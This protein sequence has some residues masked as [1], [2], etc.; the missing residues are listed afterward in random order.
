M[1]KRCI[2][3]I[4]MPLALATVMLGG[5]A[6][7]QGN[8]NTWIPVGTGDYTNPANWDA[9][10][11]PVLSPFEERAVISN[12]GTA[13]LEVNTAPVVGGVE[14]TSGTL[15]I[16]RGGTLETGIGSSATGAVTIAAGGNLTMGGLTG[17]N[18]STFT[19]AAGA[20]LQGTTNIIGPNANLS[21]A[22]ITL[23]GTLNSTVTAAGSSTLEATGNATL[24][25]PLQ[26]NFSGITPVPGNTWNIIDA[27]TITGAFSQVTSNASLGPGLFFVQKTMAGGMHGTLAQV[28]IDANLILSVNRRT[29]QTSIKNLTSSVSKSIDAYYIT[30]PSNALLPGQWSSFNDNGFTSFR[31]SNPSARHLG[32]LSISG[33]RAIGPN[34]TTALGNIFT[35]TAPPLTPTPG[36]DLTFEFHEAGGATRTGIVDYVGPHNNLVLVVNPD[37]QTFIQNQ[38][39]LNLNVDGYLISSASG[40]LNTSSWVSFADSNAAWRESNPSTKHL[41]ELNIGGSRNFAAGSA[42]VSLGSAFTPGSAKDLVFEF[43]AVGLGTLTGSVEYE[44]GVINFGT[45]PGDFNNDGHVDAA[46]YVVWRKNSGTMNPLPNDDNI[47][48]TIGTA[49]Y[50]LWRANFGTAVGSGSALN[51]AAVPEPGPVVLCLVFATAVMLT[52][53]GQLASRHSCDSAKAKIATRRVYFYR[54]A[55]RIA[56]SPVGGGA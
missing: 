39:T 47:G 41:G 12:G 4:I 40:A 9:G 48:G 25:G 20:T 17:S 32:E 1:I 16:R 56:G 55:E 51:P 52:S 46:D 42:A 22:S 26:L 2:T 3:L 37:G 54:S 24:S 18:P 28:A 29:G 13:F 38:S 30:S 33:S 49:H 19:I 50:N 43:H 34:S 11:V 45:T 44:D 6:I 36:G 27:A 21:A 8:P 7:G 31:E 14:V 35:A 10:G 15:E 23:S 5:R 53:R